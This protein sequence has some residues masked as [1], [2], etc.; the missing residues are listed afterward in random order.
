MGLR[1]FTSSDK[2]GKLTD[3]MTITHNNVIYDGL[4]M[5]NEEAPLRTVSSLDQLYPVGSIC[6]VNLNNEERNPTIFLRAEIR[7]EAE[8]AGPAGAQALS[9]VSGRTIKA[10]TLQKV[11]KEYE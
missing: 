7:M 3:V 4:V 6:N 2:G 5:D 11:T 10:E 1:G 8:W 9:L